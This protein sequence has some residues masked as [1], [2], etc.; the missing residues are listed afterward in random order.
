MIRSGA[1]LIFNVF[2]GERTPAPVTSH[3]GHHSHHSR[4]TLRRENNRSYLSLSVDR[5]ASGRITWGDVKT[6]RITPQLRPLVAVA[7][8]GFGVE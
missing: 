8:A 4:T 1:Y 3:S 6:L 5:C 7:Y 2:D